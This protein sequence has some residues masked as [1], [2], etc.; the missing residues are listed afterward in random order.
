MAFLEYGGKRVT[1]PAGDMLI[2]SGAEC[3]LRLEGP[4]ITQR[5]A[6][7]TTS[8]DLS[9]SARKLDDNASV[10]VNGV[11]LGPMPQ[12]LLHGDKLVIGG[13]ELG[14]VDERKSGSTKFVSAQQLEQMVA[15]AKKPGTPGKAT[16]A[17]GGRIVSLVDGREYQAGTSLK[18][19]RDASADVV[20]SSSQVSRR[21][22]EIVVSPRGYIVVDSSTNGSF[23]NGERVQNQRL[24]ARAD[25]LR[26]GEEEFRFYADVA[27]AAEPPA[28]EP[29]APAQL[30][31]TGYF[32]SPPRPASTVS[33]RT[34]EDIAVPEAEVPAPAPPPAPPRPQAAPPAP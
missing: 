7:L 4:G 10:E 13:H 27:P 23:V 12:P 1:V 9:V 16:A 3:H 24:L 32:P 5:A 8:A 26:L 21:H 29:K 17:T 11:H 34:G 25:I 18:F 6:V 28:V 30:V 22:A 33:P 2:G 14:F 20:I 19:G 15:A 31:S